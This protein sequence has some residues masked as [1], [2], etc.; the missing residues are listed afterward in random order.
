MRDALFPYVW[1][2]GEQCHGID[3]HP[4][5]SSLAEASWYVLCSYRNGLEG[6]G[7]VFGRL[8]AVRGPIRGCC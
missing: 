4:G 8:V 6:D 7:V 2:H 5:E 1:R 3:G